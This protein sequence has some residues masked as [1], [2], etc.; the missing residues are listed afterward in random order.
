LGAMVRSGS[1]R[2]DLHYQI[3]VSCTELPPLR[4]RV[5]DIPGLADYFAM[6]M[7]K[8]HRDTPQFSQEAL[9]LLRSHNWPGNVRE[10]RNTVERAIAGAPGE[11]IP[12][13]AIRLPSPSSAHR[14]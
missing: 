5:E 8:G 12:P 2:E 6:K 3:E 7:C 10:L 11:T 14:G 13:D 1:F 9:S 4:E